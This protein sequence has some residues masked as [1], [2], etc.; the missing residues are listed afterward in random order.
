MIANGPILHETIPIH[1]TKSNSFLTCMHH[2]KP[3]IPGQF[4]SFLTTLEVYLWDIA[5]KSLSI[6]LEWVNRTRTMTEP[7]GE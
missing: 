6:N 3:T 4:V 2:E 7:P 1:L 5:E